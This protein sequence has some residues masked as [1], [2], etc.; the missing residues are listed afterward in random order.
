MKPRVAVL[1]I[2]AA[3]AL[4]AGGCASQT[5]HATPRV[6]KIVGLQLR[7]AE[8]RLYT[9]H[10]RWRI[11]PGSQVFSRP[12]A[13][14]MHLSTDDLPVIGQSPRAGSATDRN[15]VVTIVTPCTRKHPCS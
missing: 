11:A 9:R 10:L 8:Q 3:G 1:A 7:A 4:V 6:P 5:N 14:D 2:A 15:A 12:L 13:P